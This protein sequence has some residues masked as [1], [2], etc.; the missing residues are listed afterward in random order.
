MQSEDMDTLRTLM[1]RCIVCLIAFAAIPSV[2]I[3]QP[4][5]VR[6]WYAAGQVFVVWQFP[7][8]PAAPTDT[9]EI[10][11]SAAAQVSTVNMT[12]LGRLFYPEYTGGRLGLVMA[13]ARLLVPTPGGGTYRL[14]VDEGVFV[15][16]PHAAG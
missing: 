10:Y 9:V 16:T 6:A 13:G 12:L 2:A 5:N 4:F 11:A 8:P 14:A 1:P 7:A 15:H 3:A